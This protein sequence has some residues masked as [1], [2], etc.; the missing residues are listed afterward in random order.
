MGRYVSGGGVSIDLPRRKIVTILE[1]NPAIPVPIWAQGGKGYVLVTGCGA[2]ASGS[3]G[4]YPSIGLGGGAGGFAVRHPI[5]I[6]AGV[7]SLAAVIGS[8]GG[9]VSGSTTT[10]GN[11]GGLT[12]LIVST[13]ILRL[14]GGGNSYTGEPTA[15]G[16]L[17]TCDE[18]VSASSVD[19]LSYR[20]TNYG[21]SGD[22][23]PAAGFSAPPSTLGIGAGGGSYGGNTGGFSGGGVSPWGGSALRVGNSDFSV[24]L[25]ATGYGA[26]GSGV[27]WRSGNAV[28]SGAGAPGF[29]TLEFVEGF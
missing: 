5:R 6:P 11:S 23:G 2:G 8:G 18:S 22:S 26:G 1:S 13:T 16:G 3:I 15:A 25:N 12:S 21:N 27:Q 9:S 24:G 28:T 29:L 20:Y 10:F 17:S 19:N 4:V 7:L 14:Y